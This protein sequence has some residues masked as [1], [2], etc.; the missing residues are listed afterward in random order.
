MRTATKAPKTFSLDKK[1][2][3]E[4]KLTKGKLSESERVNA[5]L[6]LALGLERRAAL[7]VEAAAVFAYSSNG[8]AERRAY[9]VAK[10][11]SWLRG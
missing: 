11:A 8:R 4:I 1:I 2:L 6:R 10:L 9:Q 5:L 3:A 7:S